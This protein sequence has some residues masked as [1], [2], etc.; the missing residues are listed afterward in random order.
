MRRH[1]RFAEK[2]VVRERG[3]HAILFV[4]E[5]GACVFLSLKD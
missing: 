2:I 1:A 5:S 4:V 3:L